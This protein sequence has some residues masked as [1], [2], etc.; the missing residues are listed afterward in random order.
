[1]L[2]ITFYCSSWCYYCRCPSRGEEEAWSRQGPQDAYLGQALKGEEKILCRAVLFYYFFY[3]SCIILP[4][5]LLE[6]AIPVLYPVQCIWGF[7]L[8]QCYRRLTFDQSTVKEEGYCI[9]V[10][11]RICRSSPKR[12]AGAMVV[13]KFKNCQHW[14]RMIHHTNLLDLHLRFALAVYKYASMMLDGLGCI[15]QKM[16]CSNM[17]YKGFYRAIK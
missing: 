9:D 4:A 2:T 3:L 12:R 14:Q 10:P 16:L 7:P 15:P 1:M 11:G 13:I 6:S 5:W 17:I 8:N